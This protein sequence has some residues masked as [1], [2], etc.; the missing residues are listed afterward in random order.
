MF[1][2]FRQRAFTAVVRGP[3][4]L[5][6]PMARATPRASAR[7]RDGRSGQSRTGDS[8]IEGHSTTGER[9]KSGTVSQ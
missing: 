7:D 6:R 9:Q 2:S 3:R 8:A 1:P 5:G 4:E